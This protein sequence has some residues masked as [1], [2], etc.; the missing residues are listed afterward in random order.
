MMSR[1]VLGISVSSA[2]VRAALVDHAQIRWAGQASYAT[3][4]DLAEVIARLA[5]EAVRVVPRARVVL[6]RDVVQ[7]RSLTPAP[8]KGKAV[9][10]WVALEA[11][12]LF[13]RNGAP[14]V[15]DGVIVPL[16]KEAAALWAAAVPEP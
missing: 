7:L 1:T 13:R 6:E 15:T 5:G 9:R 16:G 11:E 3:I 8:L 14:L 10:R 2:A 4:E 12:R